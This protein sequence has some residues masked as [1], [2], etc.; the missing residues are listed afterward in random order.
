MCKSKRNSSEKF[1]DVILSFINNEGRFIEGYSKL[2]SNVT[3]KKEEGEI[4]ATMNG[5]I[6]MLL[7]PSEDGSEYEFYMRFTN[8]TAMSRI[9]AVKELLGWDD[10]DFVMHETVPFVRRNDRS[11]ISLM[12]GKLYLK[13]ELYQIANKEEPKSSTQQSG[14]RWDNPPPK[15]SMEPVMQTESEEK[16]LDHNRVLLMITNDF[17]KEIESDSPYEINSPLS[18]AYFETA[19]IYDFKRQAVEFLNK[20][21][22]NGAMDGVVYP[23]D[24]VSFYKDNQKE[25]VE[26]FTRYTNEAGHESL[27]GYI[28]VL[29]EDADDLKHISID[30]IAILLHGDGTK[31]HYYESFATRMTRFVGENLAALYCKIYDQHHSD[32]ELAGV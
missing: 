16:R 23:E 22:S 24:M 9:I 7:E 28:M 26:W 31:N 6:I 17:I 14:V 18:K 1:A 12:N 15:I 19:N 4:I 25:L 29:T 13:H 2:V 8:A 3:V 10:I 32:S 11:L 30:D 21:N 27:I 5:R 20:R